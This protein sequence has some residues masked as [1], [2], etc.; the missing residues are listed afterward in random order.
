MP[1]LKHAAGAEMGQGARI[2]LIAKRRPLIAKRRRAI[3][4]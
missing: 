2:V 1:S 4:A 3:I